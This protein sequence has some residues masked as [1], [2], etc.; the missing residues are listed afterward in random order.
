VHRFESGWERQVPLA[1]NLRQKAPRGD[2][3]ERPRAA[4]KIE[5][6]QSMPNPLAHSSFLINTKTQMESWFGISKES[7]GHEVTRR[8]TKKYGGSR[9]QVIQGFA[10]HPRLRGWLRGRWPSRLP[11]AECATA[12]EGMTAV[13]P[14]PLRVSSGPPAGRLCVPSWRSLIL[15]NDVPSRQSQGASPIA[16]H[17]RLTLSE[18]LIPTRGFL[19]IRK[20][21]ENSP[22][23]DRGAAQNCIEAYFLG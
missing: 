19:Q 1:W 15:S 6:R 9:F 4:E 14:G 2:C 10:L 12:R 8:H 11:G 7:S 23:T 18:V 22:P 20:E 17:S 3:G 13:A 5:N 16:S 21:P